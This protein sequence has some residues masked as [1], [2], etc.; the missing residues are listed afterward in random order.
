MAQQI[1]NKTGKPNGY[2]VVRS[3][4]TGYLN[5]N[6]GT[7]PANSAGETVQSMVI[8]EVKWSVAGTNRWTV[9]RGANTVAE[10][11]YSG[12]H[13]YQESISHPSSVTST[14]AS[15]SPR[16]STGSLGTTPTPVSSR[17]P[18]AQRAKTI[19]I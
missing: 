8:S 9:K 10:Y 3:D 16:S 14:T 13:D 15:G 1:T 19:H 17:Y 11:A 18:P 6:G 5:L 12:H 7:Y 4:A 2:V